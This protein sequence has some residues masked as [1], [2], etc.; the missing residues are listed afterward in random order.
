[1]QSKRI[2]EM[3]KKKSVGT[4]ENSR[5]AAATYIAKKFGGFESDGKKISRRQG[6]ALRA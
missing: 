4:G 6:P 3:P 5:K 2:R 1:M